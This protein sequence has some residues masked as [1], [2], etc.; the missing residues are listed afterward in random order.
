MIGTGTVLNR[1]GDIPLAFQTTILWILAY[2][3]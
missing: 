1:G 3:V 2:V